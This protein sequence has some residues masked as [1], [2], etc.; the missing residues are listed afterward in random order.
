MNLGRAIKLCRVHRELSQQELADLV[1]VDVSHISLLER[2]KRNAKLSILDKLAKALGI[3]TFLLVYLVEDVD[4]LSVE[5]R[6]KL[7]REAFRLLANY[8]A[9]DCTCEKCFVNHYNCKCIECNQCHR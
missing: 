2:N 6:E 1:G 8:H 5:L 4:M 3:P 9:P 7:S